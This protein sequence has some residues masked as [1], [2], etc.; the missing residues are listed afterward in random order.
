MLFRSMVSGP[1]AIDISLPEY[2][3]YSVTASLDASGTYY[4]GINPV[5]WSDG[6]ATYHGTMN[7]FRHIYQSNDNITHPYGYWHVPDLY[8][9]TPVPSFWK[10]HFAFGSASIFKIYD[11]GVRIKIIDHNYHSAEN[12]KN[13]YI[14]GIYIP[15][16]PPYKIIAHYPSYP[17][18]GIISV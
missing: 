12:W 8:T 15:E 2:D 18:R 5:D 16:P 9:N 17:R 14:G 3:P 7:A 11:N 13:N 6:A 4:R 1:P 10:R